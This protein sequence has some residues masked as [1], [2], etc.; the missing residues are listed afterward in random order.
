MERKYRVLLWLVC[1]SLAL[2]VL[3]YFNIGRLTSEIPQ[4]TSRHLSDSLRTLESRI[5]GIYRDIQEKKE[6][7]KWVQAT[8]FIPDRY[9]SC[10]EELHLDL[11]WSLREVEKEARVSLL[12]RPEEGDWTRVEADNLEGNNYRASL[13]LS[14]QELYQYQLLAEGES[15]RASEIERVPAEYYR[16]SP[17]YKGK[18]EA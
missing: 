10:P 6:E 17:G 14:S 5:D 7:K 13:V 4:E 11:E 9:S 1:I 8:N 2:N 3:L 16:P 18:R 15:A 12:Y